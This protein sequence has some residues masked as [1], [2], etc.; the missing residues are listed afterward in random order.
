[1]IE[2]GHINIE[3]E[4]EPTGASFHSSDAF[5]RALM[6]PIGS[7]KSVTCIQEMFRIGLEQL[8]L[9]HI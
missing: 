7:G 4:A 5:V 3:Y 6:G 1:M 9:I 2:T 8:S